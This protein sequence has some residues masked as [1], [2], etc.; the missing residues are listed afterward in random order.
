MSRKIKYTKSFKSKAVNA[1]L[2]ENKGVND[3]SHQLEID[4]S[5]LQRWVKLYKKYGAAGLT[6]RISNTNYT[7]EFKL[8]VVQSIEEKGLSFKA[9]SLQYNIPSHST[10]RSWYL[11]YSNK[12]VKGL[13]ADGRG[14]PKFMKDNSRKTTGKA[15]S[16]EEELLK[17]N[18]SLKAELALLKKLHAL[19]QAKKKKQ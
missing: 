16:R 14:R 15:L 8:T 19:A 12:G 11:T 4:R 3:V 5:E 13:E 17:E 6:P 9:A 10:V 7:I 18:E 1:V 2:K